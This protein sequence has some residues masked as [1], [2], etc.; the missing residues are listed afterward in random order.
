[1]S[2]AIV[3]DILS[4]MPLNFVIIGIGNGLSL[5]RW[6]TM[7]QI[8]D[9]FSSITLN[10]KYWNQPIFIDGIALKKSSSAI[11]SA[12][13]SRAGMDQWGGYIRRTKLITLLWDS[14]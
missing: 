13:L 11:Y 2:P 8:N 6:Q 4:Y 5:A 10:E 12:I 9:D 1:M 7:V 14:L 3:G